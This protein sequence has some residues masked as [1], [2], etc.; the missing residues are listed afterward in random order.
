MFEALNL[1]LNPF[2]D[3]T[4]ELQIGKQLIWA[5][6]AEVNTKI[7]KVYVDIIRFPN[8][9]IILNW[10]PWGGGKTYS[11][12]YF[13]NRPQK[14]GEIRLTQS[15]IKAPKK[16]PTATK[17]FFISIIDSITFSEIIRQVKY[18]INEIGEEEFLKKVG[19]KIASS[20]FAKAI[21]LLASED[22]EILEL[23]QRYIYSSVTK[24]ELKKLKLPRTLSSDTDSIK[25]L[26]GILFCFTGDGVFFDGRFCLWID[27]MEDL[28]YYNSAQYR[29]FSQVLRDLIDRLTERVTVFFNFTLS[30]PE[31]KTIEL[32]LGG[33][34]W[35]RINKKIRFKELNEGD[36]AL[37]VNDLINSAL[38][39][40]KNNGP[41]DDIAIR[42][43]L[44]FIPSSNLT[45]REINKYFSGVLNFAIDNKKVTINKLL[46]EQYIKEKNEND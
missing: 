12:I 3:L 25:V 10:G 39:N 42:Y 16:G 26:S 46:I 1:N 4:P 32:L 36:A 27:E 14:K 15:Y 44:S 24:T 23:T 18:L 28:I 9:Q 2:A 11:S 45:P 43:L 31:E 22:E 5:G 6:M 34:L 33:A 8:R 38:V 20:E 19:S 37:Y 40:K 35:S 30:E 29:A 41:F 21:S 13:I 17:E 7:S